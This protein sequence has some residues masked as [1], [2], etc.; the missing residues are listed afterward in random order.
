M[1][2][3]FM[4]SFFSKRRVLQPLAAPA[5]LIPRAI[6]S[7]WLFSFILLSL[8]SGPFCVIP[9]TEP[10]LKP[11]AEHIELHSGLDYLWCLYLVGKLG[12]Q[13][14]KGHVKPSQRA[15]TG[16]YTPVTEFSPVKQNLPESPWAK[17][18]ALKPKRNPPCPGHC[19]WEP[20]HRAR[21]LTRGDLS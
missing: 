13:G 7:K 12:R 20:H 15:D 3:T 5:H 9:E 8:H 6:P 16:S 14:W 17:T 1:T 19:S 10:F 21:S 11:P 2:D 4:E 18:Y